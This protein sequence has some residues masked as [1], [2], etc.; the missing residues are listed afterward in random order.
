M[1]REQRLMNDILNKIGKERFDNYILSFTKSSLWTVIE[2]ISKVDSTFEEIVEVFANYNLV[3]VEDIL[4]GVYSFGDSDTTFD[5]IMLFMLNNYLNNGSTSILNRAALFCY[6]L[7]IICEDNNLKPSEEIYQIANSDIVVKSNN[8]ITKIKYKLKMTEYPFDAIVKK[9][10]L[11]LISIIS[12]KSMED[13]VE[14]IK[15]MEVGEIC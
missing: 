15:D 11:M 9:Q 3:R 10:A 1:L 5:G 4:K 2:H 12:G 13:S 7:S 8:I 6:M 14:Y